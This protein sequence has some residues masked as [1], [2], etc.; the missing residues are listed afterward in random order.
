MFF[1]PLHKVLLG[2]AAVAS[3]SACSGG[4]G[5]APLSTPPVN[6]L[7]VASQQ[8]AGARHTW[9]MKAPMPTARLGAAAA[10]I[11]TKIYVVGGYNAAGLL[12]VNEIYDTVANTW[13]TGAAMPTARWSLAA[14][15]VNGILYAIGGE[16]G[17]PC[18]SETNVVEAYDPVHDSWSTKA[19]MPTSRNS[20]TAVD[21][22]N[23]IYAIGGFLNG[24]RLGNVERYAPKQ[25]KWLPRA[26]LLLAKSGA[27]IGV[28]GKTIVA[29]SGLATSGL[30]TDTEAYKPATNAWASVAPAPNAQ[31][32]ACAGGIG[33]ALYSAGGADATGAPLASLAI[34]TLKPN[35]WKSGASMLQAVVGPAAAVVRKHLYCFGGANQGF[36]SVSTTFYDVV[37]EY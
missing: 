31:N 20:L 24:S 16:V 11:G 2:A 21:D 8:I 33:G 7:D 36:P 13:S 23:L 18:C 5:D 15:S 26:P 19:A 25:N 14:A 32:A 1:R 9:V 37:Q 22:A 29:A 10:A 35:S 4:A 17:S 28:I 30:T 3:L 27:S 12:N 34:Y 6:V